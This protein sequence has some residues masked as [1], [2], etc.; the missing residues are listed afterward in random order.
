MQ[1][2]R[3]L[4]AGGSGTVGSELS[5]RLS[6]DGHSVHATVTFIDARDVAAVVAKLLT[7]DDKNNRAFTITG[8]ESIDHDEVAAVLAAATGKIISY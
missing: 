7:T 2:F 8:P 6:H 5:R 3:F 4:V 1:Q